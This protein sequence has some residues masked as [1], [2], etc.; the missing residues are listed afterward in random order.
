MDYRERGGIDF[1]KQKVAYPTYERGRVTSHRVE[2]DRKCIPTIAVTIDKTISY[3]VS[4][5][6]PQFAQEI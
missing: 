5:I 1:N 6:T 2:G 3:F 4:S